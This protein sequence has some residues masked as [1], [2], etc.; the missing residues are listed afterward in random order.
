MP[1]SAHGHGGCAL[2]TLGQLP[3]RPRRVNTW[4]I[5]VL[6]TTFRSSRARATRSNNRSTLR[7]EPIVEAVW[8]S[9][10]ALNH[11]Y[12]KTGTLSVL[13]LAAPVWTTECPYILSVCL[14]SIIC[15][16][17]NHSRRPTANVITTRSGRQV[18]PQ[19]N[20]VYDYL[21]VYYLSIHYYSIICY[22][23]IMWHTYGWAISL[24]GWTTLFD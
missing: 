16:S 18:K 5:P 22:L 11:F 17:N 10:S 4:D 20:Y 9:P 21:W 8:K 19:R 7:R 14:L 12:G 23:F 3:L 1:T 24:S 2:V 6:E 15:I 13:V